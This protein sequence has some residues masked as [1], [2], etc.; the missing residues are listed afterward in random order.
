MPSGNTKNCIEFW[1]SLTK[2]FWVIESIQGLKIDFFENPYQSCLPGSIPFKGDE[3]KIVDQEVTDLLNKGAIEPCVHEANEFISN[4][5][6]VQKKNGKFRPV[7]NLKKLNEYVTYHHFKQETLDTILNNINRGDFFTSIDLKDAYFSIPIHENDRKYLKFIWNGQLYRFTSLPF[8]I[9]SAPHDFTTILKPIFAK[10]RRLGVMA[11]Y[12]IDD[13]LIIASSPVLCS[14]HC[15]L[16]KDT[17]ER[18]GFQINKEKSC[19][20]PSTVVIHLG[21]IL[22]SVSFTVSLTE[23]KIQKVI[24]LCTEIL[25][26]TSVKV[27]LVSK[28]L[29]Q[30]ISSL[31]AVRFGSLHYRITEKE[32]STFLLAGND[33]DD[34]MILSPASFSEIEWWLKNVRIM[35]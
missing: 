16:L 29:G 7:I 8:G 11:F 22:D 35:N 26:L 14:D 30:I 12:Y 9:A 25:R 23:E 13:S 32:K 3:V 4:L 2:D 21:Y 34:F 20:I 33:Y 28:L 1:K 5:F 24:N 10:V 15:S 18:A 31:K 19:F 6:L 27:R 17:F